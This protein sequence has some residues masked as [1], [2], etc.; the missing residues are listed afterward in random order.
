MALDLQSAAT[1]S[2]IAVYAWQRKRPLNVLRR[3]SNTFL[4]QTIDALETIEA[5]AEA[6]MAMAAAS[7]SKAQILTL[8]PR[9]YRPPAVPAEPPLSPS[10]CDVATEKPRPGNPRYGGLERRRA[11][12]LL[13]GMRAASFGLKAPRRLGAA[14][15]HFACS[16]GCFLL[17][18]SCAASPRLGAFAGNLRC[19]PPKTGEP[20]S[21]SACLAAHAEGR[22]QRWRQK[23]SNAESL[24]NGTG[25][26]E[27]LCRLRQMAI[28]YCQ[29][30]S[31][32][33]ELKKG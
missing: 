18:P 23:A 24:L 5:V 2:A 19:L 29:S 4:A 14:R 13:A 22:K 1:L 28:L 27:K 7:N 30:Y 9:A 12:G 21:A 8:S 17:W 11:P 10:C 16:P 6:L 26:Q 31:Q 32:R 33:S 20:P 3:I 25:G 15:L